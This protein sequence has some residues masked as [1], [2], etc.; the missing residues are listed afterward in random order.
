MLTLLVLLQRD[1]YIPDERGVIISG[2]AGLE[3]F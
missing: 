2:S 3:R 1:P